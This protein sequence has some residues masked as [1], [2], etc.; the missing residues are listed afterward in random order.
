M[1]KLV[2]ARLESFSVP[3]DDE[4]LVVETGHRRTVF[5]ERNGAYFHL[6]CIFGDSEPCNGVGEIVEPVFTRDQ[7]ISPSRILEDA[8]NLLLEL[9]CEKTINIC[10]EKWRMETRDLINRLIPL[11]Q[12]WQ[13]ASI[14]AR[15]GLEQALLTCTAKVLHKRLC[16]V[17]HYWIF[18]KWPTV[19]IPAKL[20]INSMV[21]LRA[22]REFVKPKPGL[23]TK[24][25]IGGGVS[26]PKQEAQR[27]NEYI[28]ESTSRGSW[29]RLDINQ[30]WNISQVIEFTE[31]LSIKTVAAIQYVEEPLC[32]KNG[33]DLR[34]QLEKLR[35]ACPIWGTVLRFAVDESLLFE[36]IP[37]QAEQD[38]S[39]QIIH[40]TSL[41]GI[42]DSPYFISSSERLTVT[43]TFE[44]GVGLRFLISL[45]GAVN[46]SVAHGIHPLKG[47]VLNHI[48]T[49]AFADSLETTESLTLVNIS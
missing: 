46:P 26:S 2:S 28:H 4:P 21:N 31:E 13:H 38:T 18:E 10:I 5:K 16:D 19:P 22:E 11:H 3:L 6:T 41:H 24:I 7:S 20:M 49:R 34:E 39:I 48:H 8:K 32:L 23:T 35:R 47:M 37:S 14:I 15:Y 25:K 29:V 42:I 43:C 40:K 44:T 36:N 27:L 30:H 1:M 45:A 12:D 33:E 9:S 17:I